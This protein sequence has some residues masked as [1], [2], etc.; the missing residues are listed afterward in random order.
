[1]SAYSK[2]TCILDAHVC[3]LE[4]KSHMLD[5]FT[6]PCALHRNMVCPYMHLNACAFAKSLR[7]TQQKQINTVLI[8][9]WSGLIWCCR[10]QLRTVYTI[11]TLLFPRAR[12]I[13]PD[14][15]CPPLLLAYCSLK[16]S[17]CPS[18]RTRRSMKCG[19]WVLTDNWS[20][21]GCIQESH[22][23]QCHACKSG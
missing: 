19:R 5:S 23:C 4:H 16:R 20:G 1:M 7:H 6:L 21:L 11:F 17:A 2:H 18:R 10:D 8:A 3:K 12:G 22:A 14:A 13:G 15:C 9:A